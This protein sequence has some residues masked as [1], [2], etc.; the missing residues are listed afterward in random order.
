[1]NE[2]KNSLL[3]AGTFIATVIGAGFASGQEILSYFVIYGKNSIYGLF[4][5]CTLFIMCSICVMV[6]VN[7]DN[8]D[9]FD[10]YASAICGK[11]SAA[12]IKLCVVLFMFASFCSMVAGSGELFSGS[13]GLE[14]SVGIWVML[15]ACVVV[16]LFDL[17]GILTLNSILAPIM[18]ISLFFLG[19][20]AFLFRDTATFGSGIIEVLCKNY[21]TSSL[22]YASYN[23]LTSI[24]ILAEMRSLITKKRVCFISSAI[25]GGALFF[26]A[27]A[28]WASL[29]LYFGKIP[30][31]SMPFLTVVSRKGE[32]IKLIY[33]IVVYLSMLTTAVSCGYGVLRWLRGKLKIKRLSAIILTIALSLPVIFLGFEGIVKNIY[34]LFGYLGLVLIVYILSDGIRLISD[35]K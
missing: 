34:S 10:E 7:R 24:V 18:S 32:F 12:F 1:M 11:F 6:R 16:F 14:K 15:G 20:Y 2:L 31:G 26:I 19:I 28:M 25:G 21:I 3:I 23:M 29:M 22:V 33:S 30:L 27:L 13:F 5:V 8:I 4:I 35:K 9:S 17:N